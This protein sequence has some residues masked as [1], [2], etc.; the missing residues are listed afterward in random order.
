MIALKAPRVHVFLAEKGVGSRRF[1][2]EL[3]RK[4]LVRVNNTIAKLGDKVALGDRI[5]Y[6]KQIFVFKDFQINNRIYLALNKPRNY[7]CSN[8]DV[9]GRKLAI[10]LVQP[11]FKERVFSIGRLDFKSSGLLLFTNDGKFANDIIHP[12]QKVE[13]E[14]IIES[15]KDIDENLLISFKSGI[16]VKKEFFKL[17]SYEILNKNSA[18]LILDEGKN[19]EIRKVFL[20]KNIF[21]KKIHRIRIGNINLDSLKEGQVKIVPLSKINSLKSRLEKLNDNSN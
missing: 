11:L 15:K 14:Y 18:R 21:L 5:I 16:K 20:S 3:I 6:K 9:D 17:K 19:R 8:F 7:L 2:E 10:S 4:K 12:R 1:C 13:R